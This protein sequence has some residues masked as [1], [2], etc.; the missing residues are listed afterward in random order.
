MNKLFEKAQKARKASQ[1]KKARA[2]YRTILNRPS[3]AIGDKAEALAGL[4]DV[5]RLQGSFT[6]A[7][8][9][10]LRAA[11]L[12]QILEPS[13]SWDALVG[14]ALAARAV[15]RPKEALKILN[16]ALEFY[17]KGEDLQGEA[18]THWALG[19]T[20]RIMGG[21]KEGLKELQTAL[22]MFRKLKDAEGAAYT[23]CALGGIYRM[24]GRYSESGRFYRE[25]NRRMRNRKDT[26]GIAYS[27]CG[28][29]NVERMACRFEQALPYYQKA[30]KLYGTIGDRVSYAYTLW[31]I[32]TTHK[33]LGR[34]AQAI[35][36]F[37]K[38]DKLFKETGDTRGRIYT[39]LGFAEVEWLKDQSA[40]GKAYWKKAKTIADKSDFA[41]EKL[42]MEALKSGRINLLK[43]RYQKAGSK[44]YPQSLPV[45]FP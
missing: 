5:E 42:H 37:H 6:D 23:C 27:Y 45:N 41:W 15:G 22:R 2:L 4:A 13:A 10:Y 17:R 31:S 33:M 25:A 38:A 40:R 7:L 14:W 8:G 24:L 34:Y 12:Y 20:L 36:A 28:L 29:G 35:Q 16:M 26:F 39:L 32:G 18:F 30:E 43:S 44:F 1:F 11:R 9:H 19:G 21:M 3:I